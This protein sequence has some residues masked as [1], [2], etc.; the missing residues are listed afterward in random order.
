[1]ILKRLYTEPGDIFDAV[2]FKMGSNLIFGHKAPGV[3]AKKSLNGIGKSTFLDLLDFCLLSSYSKTKNNR[4]F[5]A[6]GIL[7]KHNVALDF[8]V[9]GEPYTIKRSL[10]QPND[11]TIVTKDGENDLSIAEGKKWLSRL[12]F[13]RPNYEGSYSPAWYR[14][15]MLLFLKIH[16]T[17]KQDKYIDPISYVDKLSM[18]ELIQ[19]HLFMLGLDNTLAYKNNDIQNDKAR[20]LPALREVKAI[21]EETYAVR[22]IEDANAQM[23]NLQSEIKAL[24][25]T[26]KEFK[27]SENYRASEEDI[28][29]LTATIKRL[30]LLNMAD[31]K[32]IDDYEKSLS[33]QDG[34]SKRDATSVAKIYKELNE[35]FS[36]KIKLTLDAAISFRKELAES[37]AEFIGGELQKLKRSVQDRQTEIDELDRKRAGILNF[38]KTKEAISDLT[39]AFSALSEKKQNLLDISSKLKTYNTLEKEKVEIEGY[40]KINDSAILG[41]VEKLQEQDVTRLH[42]LFMTVYRNIYNFNSKRPPAF[43]ITHKMSTDAKIAID[44]SIPADNSKANNQGRTLVYDLMLMINMLKQKIKGPRFIVHDG[45]FDGMDK[46]HFVQLHRFL[47]ESNEGSNLQYIY[48][49]NEEGEL[50]EP[51]GA[52]DDVDVEHLKEEAILVLTPDHK[53]LGEFDK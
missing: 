11:I 5:L 28:N 47:Q 26:L 39:E 15:L 31:H 9:E 42:E 46:A 53:L 13:E 43:S 30:V 25:S 21:V 34:F 27:L 10:D 37:R 24:E 4:L 8:E 17:K 51:F 40:E 6:Y 41:Y 50:T 2:E 35:D 44:V 22:D 36:L 29:D 23:L 52:T 20:K 3:N 38:L 18:H 7:T 32:R 12:V 33:S 16:K 49:L 14:N 45:I 19:Y 1:M 48:T